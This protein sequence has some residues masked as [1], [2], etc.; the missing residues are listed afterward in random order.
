MPDIP[1]VQTCCFCCT[2]EVGCKIIGW[3]LLIS[4]VLEAITSIIF[5]IGSLGHNKNG[6]SPGNY[7]FQ[8]LVSLLVVLMGLYLLFG[9]YRKNMRYLKTW[10]TAATIYL[11]IL[12]IGII[13]IIFQGGPSILVQLINLLLVA[14]FIIVVYSFYK[15]NVNAPPTTY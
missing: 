13:A 9:V 14:Y 1:Q 6:G 4:G 12:V 5:L 2:T 3:W 8:L 11:V 7:I 10:L 15:E